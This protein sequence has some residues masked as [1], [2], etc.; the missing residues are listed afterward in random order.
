[1]QL[2]PSCKRGG[3]SCA[4]ITELVAAVRQ[5]ANCR[6]F[7]DPRHLAH[8][9]GLNTC[10]D[11]RVDDVQ[12]VG[13]VLYF[14]RGLSLRQRGS[15]LYRALGAF[16]CPE[17]Q[18]AV[19]YELIVPHRY[20]APLEALI[21]TQQHATVEDLVTIHLLLHGSGEYGRRHTLHQ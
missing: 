13:R 17:E 2:L 15:L 20:A 18:L 14:G 21:V 9:M 8:A 16:I 7:T 12:L 5:N 19:A 1:M 6:A 10:P 3:I 4:E 11:S